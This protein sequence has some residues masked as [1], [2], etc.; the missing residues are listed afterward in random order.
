MAQRLLKSNG[1]DN[2]NDVKN[3]V[4][5]CSRCNRKKSNLMGLWYIRGKLGA[6]KWYWDIT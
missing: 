4:A 2:V 6:C 5:S 3:L 1:C